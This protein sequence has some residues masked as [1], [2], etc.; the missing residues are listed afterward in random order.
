MSD[1]V[2]LL[3]SNKIANLFV[4]QDD[5]PVAIVH[6]AELMQAGYVA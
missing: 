6:I 1:V 5:R 2:D 4:V 3:A